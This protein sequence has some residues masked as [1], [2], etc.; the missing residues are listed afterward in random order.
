MIR[1]IQ[2]IKSFGVFADFQWPAGLTEFKQFNLIYGWNYSGKTTLSRAFRCFEQKRPHLDFAAAQV[3]LKTHDG[4]V[5]HLSV[6]DT[7][8]TFR[9]FNSDFVRENL[10]FADGSAAPILVLGAEDIANQEALQAKKVE[11][12]TLV[13][14]KDSNERKRATKKVA[15]E[16]TLSNYARDLI[17]NPLGVPNYERPNFQ[18]KVDECK[19][20]PEEQLLEDEVLAQFIS[21]Y[22]SHDKKPHLATKV[23]PLSSVSGAKGKATELLA[24]V[25]TASNPIPRLKDNP[26]VERWV[27]EGRPLHKEKAACQFCGQ[28]LPSDLLADLAGHFSADYENLMAELSI[29][30]NSIKAAQGEKIALASK[31]DLYSE[32]QERYVAEQSRLND[33]LEARKSTLAGLE[34]AVAAKQTKAF[35]SLECPA[36]DDPG[37]QITSVVEAINKII[38]EHNNRT[39]DFDKKRQ[40]AFAKLERHYAASFVRD[41]NYNEHATQIE[42]LKNTVAGQTKLLGELDTE[43]RE[44]EQAVSDAAKG[45]EGINALL[46]AYFGKDDLRVIVSADKRFQIVRGGVV[47]KN[48]SE[49][50]KTAIAFAYFITR[51]QDGRHPLTDTRIIID[52]PISSLDANH[53]FN[54]YALIKT[55]LA[56]CRQLFISTHSFEFYNLI[57]EWVSDDEKDTKKPQTDWKKWGVFLVKRTDDNKAVLEEIPKELLKFKSE[58]HYL[59]STLYHFDKA[60]SDDFDCLLGLP[61]VIRRFMEAFG[62]IMIPLSTGLKGKMARLFADEVVRERVWKFINYYSH[63]TTLTRSLT[64]P[65]TS[66]CKAV[67]QACLKAVK[68]WD[69]DY[70]NDL[71]SEVA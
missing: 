41:Q 54:T 55:Q 44:L 33:L 48:L 35:T 46:A 43:I 34:R 22:R 51:V 70:F 25:V 36:I 23:A 21:V 38:V 64:I 56:G 66:E 30:V 39:A 15:I 63:N 69:A 53:L 62:G 18:P 8:P 45:A 32:L 29:L 26:T 11:R 37:M 47:A 1:R 12:D 17:K 7:A 9:V 4:T 42:E 13:L 5:H 24:R 59:F 19:D 71:E 28:P 49:G 61:N 20:A 6:P 2:H 67:V 58:Y 40:E 10:R 65:D 52:D 60:G 68:D 3:Q 14:T 31:G 16:K 27:K 57:R 50:E